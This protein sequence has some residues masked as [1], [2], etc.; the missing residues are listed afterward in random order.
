[1]RRKS[2]ERVG[3]EARALRMVVEPKRVFSELAG[4]SLES[5]KNGRGR[6]VRSEPTTSRLSPFDSLDSA[7]SCSRDDGKDTGNGLH[8]C[9]GP[10]SAFLLSSPP[11]SDYSSRLLTALPRL[12]TTYGPRCSQQRRAV[13]VSDPL[14]VLSTLPFLLTTS[15]FRL[16][17]ADSGFP[18][19]RP[20]PSSCFFPPTALSPC[21]PPLTV[22]SWSS[23]PP[24]TKDRASSALFLPRI[25]PPTPS[26]PSL[27]TKRA[28]PQKSLSTSTPKKRRKGAFSSSRST[29]PTLTASRLHFE[30]LIASLPTSTTHLIKLR[31]G[32]RSLTL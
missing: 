13:L 14:D 17:A 5:V 28:P 24:A 23:V 21:L 11:P 9:T 2:R 3:D 27:E 20:S 1:M 31:R 30:M 19:S 15:I 8:R 32:M 4:T 6:Q 16:R 10:P 7:C 26:A 12:V 22:S 25:H 18:A 29:S